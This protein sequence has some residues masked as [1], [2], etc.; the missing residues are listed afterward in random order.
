LDIL[1][2]LAE[3]I[4]RISRLAVSVVKCKDWC[5]AIIFSHTSP[6]VAFVWLVLLLCI[7]EFAVRNL[8]LKQAFLAEVFLI[9]LSSPNYC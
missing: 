1:N 6:N 7:L 3:I 2:C 9:L 5:I 4:A 8:P